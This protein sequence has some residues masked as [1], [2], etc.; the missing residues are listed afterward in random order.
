MHSMSLPIWVP[1]LMGVGG[2]Y[3]DD[4]LRPGKVKSGTWSVMS[5]NGKKI[6]N[7]WPYE[8]VFSDGTKWKAGDD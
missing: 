7:A 1:L 6:L 4:G 3:D 2:G 5:R 8:V